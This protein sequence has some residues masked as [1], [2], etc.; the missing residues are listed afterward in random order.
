PPP[1]GSPLSPEEELGTFSVPPGFKV[2]LVAA[3]PDGGKYVAIVFD[4]AGRMWTMTALEYPLDA[5]EAP[6]EAKALFQRGGRD[7]VLVFDTPTAAGR[8]KPRTFAEGLAIPLGLLPYRDGAFVQYDGEIRFYR[9]T[10]GDGKSDSFT[11]VLTGFGIEDSHLFAHQFTRAPGGW[12]LMAQG[13]FNYSKVK[14]QPGEVTEFNKTKLA[15]F[16]PDGKRFEII[17]WGPC[18]IWGL[19][20]DRFGEIFIQ[21]ANDQ[22]W[23][24]MP[25]LEGASYPLC[26]DDVPRPYAPPFPKTGEQEMGGTGLSGLA[27]SEGADSFPPPWRN[28]FFVA[29]PI[30]GKIQAIRCDR[31]PGASQRTNSP[32]GGT[33]VAGRVE[34]AFG[35]GWQLE[36]L[37]D[38]LL[39]SDPWFRPVA[40]SFG[41]DGCL[42]IVDWYN[43]IIS[44]NE[45]PRNHPERD[46][47]RGRVWRV[48]HESQP[49]REN[50]PNL[51]K[52]SDSELLAHLVATNTWEVNA[53][54]QEIVDRHAVSLA[55]EL[56]KLVTDEALPED[57]RIRAL[58]CLE[59]L[60]ALNRAPIE[61][62]VTDRHRSMRK[63]AFRALRYNLSQPLSVTPDH[64][65]QIAKRGLEDPDRL[66]R[67]EVIRYLGAMLSNPEVTRVVAPRQIV[68]Q[69]VRAAVRLPPSRQTKWPP[70][71]D[72]F[73]RYLVRLAL[74][75]H[76][77]AIDAWFQTGVDTSSDLQVRRAFAALAQGG[78]EGARR[79][80][81]A[82][83]D[84]KRDP[85]AEEL[86]LIA[87]VPNESAA[88]RTLKNALSQP[89]GLRLLYD[90]RN[91][92]TNHSDLAPL[93][94]PAARSLVDRDPSAANQ[95]L[96]AR[97]ASGF[98]LIGLEDKLILAATNPVAR[99]DLQLLAA[100]ALRELGST[101]V[102]ALRQLAVSANDPVRREA[103]MA[104][105][106]AK[107][108]AAVPALL[109]V[110]PLLTPT[111]RKTAVD[112]LASSTA[113]A[114][115]LMAAIGS[116]AIARDEL[117]GYTLDKLASVLPDN[118]EVKQ[119]QVELGTG[120]KPVLRLDGGD[121][122]YVATDITLDGPFTV[123]TW[124]KLDP[125]IDNTDSILG[126]PGALD[127][128]FHESRFRVWI[129]G[130]VG[131]IVIAKKPMTAEAWTHVAFTRDADGRFRIYLN[132][133]LDS[134]SEQTDK[135]RL[136]HL[137]VG[138]SNPNGGTAGEFAEF[139]IWN[140][141]RTADAI[142]A[143]ANV[144]L[145]TVD[146]GPGR[147]LIY[148]GMG[149]SWGRVHGNAHVQRTTDLPPILT[150][151]EARTL[152]EKFAK[153][154]L[155]ANQSGDVTRGQQVFTTVCGV[156]H[157]VKGQGGKIGPVLDGAGANGVESLL[158]NILTP[159]AAMEAGYR[160]FRVETRDGDV[161]EGLLIAQDGST[162]TMRQPNTEDLRIA[163]D[164]IK[165]AGFMKISIM[166][167][168]LLEGSKP[169]D[170][171]DLFA[172][173]KTLK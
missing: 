108:D 27:L 39:S 93:L 94:T 119:L 114:N 153:F 115:Q 105:A 14:T 36:H 161:L 46:K 132:G 67:Q 109:E 18:N 68:T 56:A 3:E 142:R 162:V 33:A 125:G 121:G 4:H 21:E 107:T 101:H 24:M 17:G 30:T 71:F 99:P 144:A 80:A 139:R 32:A 150:E 60:N 113:S 138:F 41:P 72:A 54:W 23:P 58:W 7:R 155:L 81:E 63:E 16:T 165:R 31:N 92:L 156:C 35:N 170:V 20:L 64:F 103:V 40:M 136:E 37:P 145:E 78:S 122:D 53:A 28:V 164:T 126:G 8:Q 173:L 131:D 127:A 104:L 75:T 65:L 70:Y 157:T 66:V 163:R 61:K 34:P 148:H 45:V 111:L 167:E 146:S 166:P 140:S 151:A 82:L 149:E 38:F 152:E 44:H 110:W 96:M 25:F 48:R 74:E 9:D 102:D 124:V 88:K 49:L 117:D 120:L 6:A 10:D 169:D 98:K 43:K 172:Y 79:L 51:Y 85:T 62:L 26:G 128:N 90:N 77:A 118:A 52:A 160:R 73:E 106:A 112:R 116:G 76:P 57:V 1:H 133:E 55:P 135:R 15:R 97:L 159:N 50:V 13:A 59:G 22:G 47:T 19:V 130:G 2:E 91:R 86:L 5:N 87:S 95:E 129:G 100:R 143:S 89:A 123:E 42:Y 171:A 154:R 137:N 84:L 29:N 11:P 12:I 158:R 69:L 141:C 168:G 134:V 147:P 83:P